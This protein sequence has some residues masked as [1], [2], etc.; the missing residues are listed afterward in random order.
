MPIEIKGPMHPTSYYF[1]VARVDTRVLLYSVLETVVLKSNW[2]T[3]R[4]YSALLYSSQ[5]MYVYSNYSYSLHKSS[6][7]FG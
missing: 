7:R 5:C 1:R 2:P 3:R 6:G 4:R